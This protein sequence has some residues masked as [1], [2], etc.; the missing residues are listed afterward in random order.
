MKEVERL[1]KLARLECLDC[2]P[3]GVYYS[4]DGHNFYDLETHAGM[5]ELFFWRWINR[6]KEFPQK[7]G[8]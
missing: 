2:I 3:D 1:N 5:G 6:A 7:G 4:N 8:A